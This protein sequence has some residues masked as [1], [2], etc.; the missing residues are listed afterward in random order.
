MTAPDGFTILRESCPFSVEDVRDCHFLCGSGPLRQCEIFNLA[1]EVG[2]PA[3]T[4]C[5]PDCKRNLLLAL[6]F[7]TSELTELVVPT[8]TSVAP[9]AT[10]TPAVVRPG[11]GNGLKRLSGE[12]GVT[13]ET[14]A[15]CPNLCGLAGELLQDCSDSFF[16][17]QVGRFGCIRC[18][19][20]CPVE[21]TYKWDWE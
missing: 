1:P 7:Y 16:P 9:G 18:L 8:C 12:C 2:E 21:A 17:F 11:F 19:P 20:I 4:E 15:E 3:C 13:N 14:A 6:L 5:L 10:D